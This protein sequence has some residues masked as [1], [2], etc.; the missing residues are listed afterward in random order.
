MVRHDYIIVSSADFCD[1]L[2]VIVLFLFDSILSSVV[3]CVSQKSEAPIMISINY[4]RF[5]VYIIMES[6]WQISNWL[7]YGRTWDVPR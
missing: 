4:C 1:T 7:T 3:Y 5:D 2:R 6:M